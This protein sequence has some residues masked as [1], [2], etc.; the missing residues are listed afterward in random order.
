MRVGIRFAT[1]ADKDADLW[2]REGLAMRPAGARGK[3]TMAAATEERR[4]FHSA[5]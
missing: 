4:A 3:H 5:L 1:K 2:Q